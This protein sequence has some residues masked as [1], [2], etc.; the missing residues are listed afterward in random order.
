M[1]KAS[2]SSP[3]EEYID[4]DSSNDPS[5]HWRDQRLSGW[6][7]TGILLSFGQLQIGR[8][9]KLETQPEI[10]KFLKRLLGKLI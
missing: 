10:N 2:K 5:L 8:T 7:R 3:V 9:F 6:D 1:N 4:S